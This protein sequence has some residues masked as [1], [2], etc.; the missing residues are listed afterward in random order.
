MGRAFQ[1]TLL[2]VEAEVN[3]LLA[4]FSRQLPRLHRS[5]EN[6]LEDARLR[7][8]CGLLAGIDAVERAHP[9]VVFERAAVA[10]VIAFLHRL[11]EFFRLPG[12]LQVDQ[13]RLLPLESRRPQEPDRQVGVVLDDL[14]R[15]ENLAR[16]E[17]PLDLSEDRVQRPVLLAQELRPRKAVA[18]LA[19][20]GTG[21]GERD[22]IQVRGQRFESFGG[23]GSWCR[24][25]GP[26]MDLP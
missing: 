14:A 3:D 10:A 24:E 21:A 8:R 20:H 15:V 19:G 25:E 11:G 18:M 26:K 17:D 1:V 4:P 5:F 13:R 9:Q 2:A 22:L 12:Q 7:A 23:V 6:R 16:V